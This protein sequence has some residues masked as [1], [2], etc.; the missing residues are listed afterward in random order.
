MTDG[1]IRHRAAASPAVARLLVQASSSS[2]GLADG[3][4]TDLDDLAAG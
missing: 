4:V 1:S 2:A 3:V